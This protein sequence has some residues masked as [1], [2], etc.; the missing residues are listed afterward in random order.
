MIAALERAIELEPSVA[1]YNALADAYDATDEAEKATAIRNKLNRAV[2]SQRPP[3][4]QISQPR[5]VM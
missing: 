4:R 5:K 2:S 3:Q 1:S